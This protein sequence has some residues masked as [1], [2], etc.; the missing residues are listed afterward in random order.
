MIAFFLNGDAV[1]PD[2]KNII[3]MVVNSTKVRKLIISNFVVFVSKK[4][5]VLPTQCKY[6]EE[7]RHRQRLGG[8]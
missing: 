2:F 5:L 6:K 7:H 4:L 8:N 1:V 3:I